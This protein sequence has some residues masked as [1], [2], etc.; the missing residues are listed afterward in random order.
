MSSEIVSLSQKFSILT[1]NQQVDSCEVNH[2]FKEECLKLQKLTTEHSKL[3]NRM[4]SSLASTAIAEIL[5]NY[6]SH[7]VE[8]VVLT[9]DN[10][11]D[12]SPDQLKFICKSL[13]YK[14]T[15]SNSLMKALM[16]LS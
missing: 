10:I 15:I 3:V 14:Y 13:Q 9:V 2:A 7:L 6:Y 5:F 1:F 16:K 12:F 4:M 8:E 11:D